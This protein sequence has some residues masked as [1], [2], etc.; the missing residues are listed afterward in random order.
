MCVHVCI[1][2]VLFVC[3]CLWE[4]EVPVGSLPL[5]LSTLVFEIKSLTYS[6]TDLHN[7]LVSE[8]QESSCPHLPM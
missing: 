8:L 3:I 7:R 5:S 6:H 4:T 2:M 1:F